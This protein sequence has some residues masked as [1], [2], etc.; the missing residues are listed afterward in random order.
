MALADSPSILA[1]WKQDP[2][3]YV[4]LKRFAQAAISAGATSE[5]CKQVGPCCNLHAIVEAL[6][7]QAASD[8]CTTV[9]LLVSVLV[10]LAD[11]TVLPLP[12]PDG[13]RHPPE[14]REQRHDV[15]HPHSVRHQVRAL[16]MPQRSRRLQVG[17]RS[18]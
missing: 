6:S 3:T 5:L 8:C 18:A 13:R 7:A 11:S 1:A 2:K 10:T 4:D 17:G 16:P 12:E 9:P 14:R 15:L